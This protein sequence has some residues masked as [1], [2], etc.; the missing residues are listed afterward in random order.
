MVSFTILP[1]VI[2]VLVHATLGALLD[3]LFHGSNA[4]VSLIQMET[5]VMRSIATIYKYY[6]FTSAFLPLPPLISVAQMLSDVSELV[7]EYG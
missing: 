3:E 7:R 4:M 6:Y 5:C 1:V 2:R